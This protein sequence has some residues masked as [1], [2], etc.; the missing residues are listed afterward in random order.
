MIAA[1]PVKKKPHYVYWTLFASCSYP[2]IQ[3]AKLPL[4]TSSSH[5]S[6]YCS[7]G[8][9]LQYTSS[10]GIDS[11]GRLWVVS[12]SQSGAKP[13][14]V[15]V[16][17][18]PLRAT[19][20]QQYTFVLSG[21]NGADALAFD[22]SRNLWVSSP[23][24]SSIL[25]YKGPFTKS[26][27]LTPALTVNVRSGYNM[28]SLA[29]DKSAN[30]YASNANS[31]GRNSIGVLKPPYTGDPYF[32][33][34]LTGSGGLAFD[35]AGNL[36]ASSNGSK[37]ALVRYNSNDLKSGDKPSIV[38]PAGLPASS[39]EAAFVFTATGDL[40]AANCGNA[41]SA[42]IDVWP[43]SRTKFGAKLKP[44]VLYTNSDLQQ[45]GCAWGIAIK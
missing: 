4:K 43:L 42:G 30:L 11:S 26:G 41:G 19:S 32:L 34:G 10:L 20:V 2:Q 3:F 15:A 8:N 40:F 13:S 14:E 6:Y 33:N 31:K 45:V 5:T 35:K 18:L 39:Y 23:G 27:T 44:S 1:P 16:F 24:N 36:Y 9:G 29:F 12:F 22:P 21:T 28:Y 7:K 37:P 38:D 25:E 17:K